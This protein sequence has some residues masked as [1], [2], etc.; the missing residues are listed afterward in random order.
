MKGVGRAKRREL[1]AL[2]ASCS[3]YVDYL[4]SMIRLAEIPD[5]R[6]LCTAVGTLRG[7]PIQIEPAPL[8]PPQSGLWIAGAHRDYIFYARDASPLHCEHIVSHE[9]AHLLYNHPPL[10]D[11]K[12]EQLQLSW[13]SLVDVEAIREALDS[14]LSRSRYDVVQERDAELLATLIEQRWRECRPQQSNTI[15]ATGGGTS[16]P[17]LRWLQ[18][19]GGSDESSERG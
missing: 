18:A 14:A 11:E 16:Q 7:R 2:Q 3:A 12:A 4:D 15:K 8:K 6:S 9:L 1:R 13:F 5:I 19:L 10:V 17:A